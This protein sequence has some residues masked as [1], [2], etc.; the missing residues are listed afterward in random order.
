MPYSLREKKK[1]KKRQV[2]WMKE[3]L[4]LLSNSFFRLHKR[5]RVNSSH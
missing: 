3:L 4:W 2:K 1:K 5:K